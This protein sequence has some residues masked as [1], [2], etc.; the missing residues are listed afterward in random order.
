MGQ[1]VVTLNKEWS[2]VGANV[3]QSVFTK[4]CHF[5]EVDT[6]RHGAA[7]GLKRHQHM[8]RREDHAG[9]ITF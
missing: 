6:I 7:S 4:V 8:T 3:G 9:V 1:S 5:L 2:V